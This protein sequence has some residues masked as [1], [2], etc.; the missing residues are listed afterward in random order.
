MS[1]NIIID[2]FVLSRL[3]FSSLV[4]TAMYAFINL[5]LDC[6]EHCQSQQAINKHDNT[7]SHLNQWTEYNTREDLYFRKLKE[8]DQ[9]ELSNLLKII[10][11]IS[12]QIVI[13]LTALG[14]DSKT[15]VFSY[16]WAVYCSSWLLSPSSSSSWSFT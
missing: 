9:S 2:I 13:K 5:S 10:F 8:H 4:I 1:V 15:A 6:N 16:Q 7:M 11:K 3:K 12:K 14:K